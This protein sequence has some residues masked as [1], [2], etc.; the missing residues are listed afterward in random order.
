MHENVST[1]EASCPSCGF[2][3]ARVRVH[4]NAFAATCVRCRRT[5]VMPL[6]VDDDLIAVDGEHDWLAPVV[7]LSAHKRTRVAARSFDP[8]GAAARVPELE[9]ELHP[10]CKSIVLGA[11]LRLP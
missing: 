3:R 10:M 5:D 6:L 1:T 7:E 4:G 9:V 8:P 11:E 2:D